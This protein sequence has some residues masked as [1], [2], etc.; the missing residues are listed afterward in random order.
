MESDNK[1]K[2]IYILSQPA[3]SWGSII[4]LILMHHIGSLL[5]EEIS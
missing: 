3:L 4:A 2:R 5:V 1:L